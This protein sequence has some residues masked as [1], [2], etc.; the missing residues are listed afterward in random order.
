MTGAITRGTCLVL[1]ISMRLWSQDGRTQPNTP[2]H[3]DTS[4]VSNGQQQDTASAQAADVAVSHPEDRMMTPPPVAVQSFPMGFTSE[5]RGSYFS[6]GLDFTTAYTDNALYGLSV[7]PVSDV[8]YSVAPTI[9]ADKSTSRL[10][11]IATYAPGFTFYQRLSERNESDHNALLQISYRLSPH[12]TFAAEDSFQKSSNV[13]NNPNFGPATA[14]SGAVQVSNLSVIAPIADRLTNVGGAGITYQFSLNGLIGASGSFTRLDYPHPS[15]V[16]GLFNSNSQAGTSFYS[17]R[18][19][20]VHYIGVTYQYQRLLAYP[21]EGH[22]ETQ[23]HAAFIFYTFQPSEHFSISLFGGPQYS[24]TILPPS[25]PVEPSTIVAKSWDPGAG[26]S[27]NW[28]NRSTSFA[29]SYA[30]VITGGGGLVGAVHTQTASATLKRQIASR[31][32]V[33]LDGMYAQNSVVGGSFANSING[34]TI[35]GGASLQ[36][37]LGQH[38]SVRLGYTRLHQSYSQVQTLSQTPDTNREFV[39][40]AYQFS[41]PLGR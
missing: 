11:L 12:V 37:T 10:R 9:T 20:R 38:V 15:Q 13:F 32:N 17:L 31:L 41:R 16:P 36:Q 27:L 34:H 33:T 25:P 29:G 22:S 5:G 40:I 19:S 30:R 3:A 14:V 28:R 7:A 2:Q 6:Y 18:I 8:S 24:N 1:V 26:T 23:T 39:S 35:S 21:A 4:Q